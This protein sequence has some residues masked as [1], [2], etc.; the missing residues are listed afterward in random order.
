M[1]PK[2]PRKHLFV[3]FV[4][5]FC[6]VVLSSLKFGLIS[7]AEPKP[8]VLPPIGA[9]KT[10]GFAAGGDVDSD[11]KADPGDT[12][13]Y[14]VTITN[15]ATDATGVTINDTLQSITTLAAGSVIASPIAVNDSFSSIGNVGISVPM[16]NGVL[17]NDLNPNGAGTLTI[18][19]APSTST[20]GGNITVNTT[21]GSFTYNPPV[22]FEG[23]DTFTYTLSNGTGL[24]DTGTVSITVSGMIW[25]INNGAAS[26]TTIAAGCGRLNSPFSA[27]ASFNTANV[28]GGS[29]PDNNDNIFIFESG[30]GYSGA[31]TLRTGQKLIGQDATATLQS[32]SGVTIPPFSS[33][34]LPAM[35]SANGTITNLTSTVTLGASTTLRGFSINSTT[36]TGVSGGAVSG[37]TTSEV[38]VATTTGTAVS[39]SGTGGTISFTSVSSNGAATGISLTNTTGSFT[40]TGTG[41]TCT[42]A[43]PTCTGGSIQSSTGRGITLNKV[44]SLSLTSMKIQNSGTF[45]I[46]TPPINVITPDVCTGACINGFT[47][48]NSIVTDAAGTATDD[49][50]VLTNV[51]GAVSITNSA[52]SNSPHNGI[53]IDNFNYNMS[54]FTMTN[55]TIQCQ[56]GQTCATGGVTGNDAFLLVM[57]G[58][59][60][61]TS[62]I[63]S[64][65]TI[66]GSRAVGVQVQTADTGRIGTNS[67]GTITAAM[68]VQNNTFTGNGIGIDIDSSQVSSLTFQVLTNTIV[69][70]VTAP[71]A[72]PNTTSSHAINAFTAAGASTGPAA[73]SFVGKIDG[74]II[75]TQGVKDSG[76]G[77]GSGIRVVVQGQTTQGVVSVTN[78]TIR[79]VPNATILNFIGQNGNATT[80]TNSARFKITGNS[81]PAPTGSNLALCGPPNSP[82]G[83]NGIFVL[84][85][86]STMPVC[87]VITGNNVFDLSAFGFD[88]YLAER[89]G[90]PAGAQLTVEGTGGSNSAYI[91]ANNTLAGPSKF[92]DEGGNTSQVGIGACGAFPTFAPP[93]EDGEDKISANFE[94]NLN[95]TYQTPSEMLANIQPMFKNSRS[96]VKDPEPTD[97]DVSVSFASIGNSLNRIY[98][99]LSEA[100]SPTVIAGENTNISNAPL[101][102]ETVTK[103]LGTIPANEQVVVRFNATV[104]NGPFAAGVNNITNQ[105]T[106]SG[107]NFANALTNTTS[108][109]LDAAPDLSVTKSDGATT[110]QPGGTVAYTLNYA[111]ATGNN[112]QNATGVVLNETVPANTTFNAGAST[113]GWV[114]TPNN[115]AGSTCTLA[116]GALN[117]GA[118]GSATF[119][120][121]VL[122]TLPAVSTVSNTSTIADDAANGADL[123]GA[124]NTGADTTPIIGVWLGGTST[125]WFT[126]SNWSNSTI[127]PSG[128]NVAVPNVANQ[129]I[130][131]AADVTLNNLVLNGENVTLNAN[132]TLTVNGAVTL[133]SNNIDGAGILAL[134]ASATI[135]RTTGQVNTLLR[136]TYGGAGSFTFPVGTANGFSPA[137]V[138][139]TAGTFPLDFNVRAVQGPQP[140]L[141]AANSLQRYWQVSPSGG[142]PTANL[143]FNYLQTDVMGTET[144][145]KIVRINGTQVISIA[146]NPPNVVIDTTNNVATINGVVA[147]SDWTLGALVPTAANVPVAGRVLTADGRG[148]FNAE[149]V[150]VNSSGNIL[151]ARTNHFGYYRFNEVAAGETYTM[152]VRHKLYVF[153]PQIQTINDEAS[154][155]IFVAS[156]E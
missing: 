110:T 30:T 139:V 87:S 106:I 89:A 85:D 117:A 90:P 46:G 75:G 80:G 5:A 19:S 91:Q 50:V 128:N 112:L 22:G 55:S 152:S 105:A 131:T 136:K 130:I 39:L 99:G 109:M 21:D 120:V 23:T 48:D 35:N 114:C 67:G 77:I 40:V 102:G 58:T 73:H 25:F 14:T 93:V 78:N 153:T 148:V 115:N 116:V 64:G 33:P 8:A 97:S 92:V 1:K 15:G 12:L 144:S 37:V 11:G 133:G 38:N 49:G 47:L 118:N 69:A 121:N 88:I 83:E 59:S 98:N 31:V 119:A 76:S 3:F 63:I 147:F 96:A 18:T 62:G 36:S 151:T 45:G 125:D 26:C 107:S 111:N 57:K 149:V 146:N 86:E 81:M 135:T 129:P 101:S 71:N 42:I 9:T 54:S 104:D 51:T 34:A 95:P 150:M 27:L 61:L 84:A 138:N 140:L 142:N 70:K 6:V 145:Y 2:L 7:K 100:I 29:N 113:A 68:V 74:N 123:N 60:V 17:A 56:T 155:I 141:S 124:N 134:G 43:T 156:R 65:N 53:T 108:I 82:C 66:T 137:T 52:I 4:F 44:Q 32:I 143:T 20:N 132:R 41:G 127:P 28:G 13:Q 103:A 24:T 154:E 126:A 94:Y 16:A 10:V 122:G 72:V 79:E